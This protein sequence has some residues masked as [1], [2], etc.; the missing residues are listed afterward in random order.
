MIDR[1]KGTAQ[2]NEA[3]E[4]QKEELRIG[5]MDVER[6]EIRRMYETGEISSEQLKD[7]RRMINYIE[8]ATL[9]EHTE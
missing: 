5:V 1:L 7:L 6:A 3:V 2:F 4:A 8:S 9:Y